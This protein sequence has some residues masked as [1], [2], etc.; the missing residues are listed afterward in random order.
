MKSNKL[1]GPW[2]LVS[3]KCSPGVHGEA[4]CKNDFPP[5][6]LGPQALAIPPAPAGPSCLFLFAFGWLTL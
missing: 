1:R 3:Y 4:S 2:I 5:L 6:V